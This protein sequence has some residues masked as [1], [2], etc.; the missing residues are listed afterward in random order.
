MPPSPPNPSRHK[1]WICT[2]VNLLAFPGL[3]TIM[4]GRRIG[5]VQAAVM[6]VGFGLVMAFFITSFLALFRLVTDPGWG[7]QRYHA[8]IHAWAWS[9]KSGML[10]SVIAWSWSLASSIAIVRA[11]PKTPP[12]LPKS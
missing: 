10:L 9:G 11:A 1:A 2:A 12:L 8:Q 4:A 6:V 3:G 7:E 5:Y